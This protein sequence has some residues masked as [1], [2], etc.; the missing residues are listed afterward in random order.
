MTHKIVQWLDRAS[1]KRAE[2]PCFK[3]WMFRLHLLM[4]RL[5]LKLISYVIL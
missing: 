4:W 2:D 1:A 5:G 3:S